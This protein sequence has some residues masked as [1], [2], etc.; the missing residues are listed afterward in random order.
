L[1]DNIAIFEIEILEITNSRS[2][3]HN[4]YYQI[5]IGE[6]EVAEIKV[7]LHLVALIKYQISLFDNKIINKLFILY[8]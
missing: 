3:E 6:T 4:N 7:R 5:I 2:N 1:V 8:H